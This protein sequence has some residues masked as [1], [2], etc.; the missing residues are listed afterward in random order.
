MEEAL[1]R[2]ERGENLDTIEEEL[3]DLHEEEEALLLR[4]NGLHLKWQEGHYG[5]IKTYSR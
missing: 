2:M 5:R 3:G 4:G 1:R